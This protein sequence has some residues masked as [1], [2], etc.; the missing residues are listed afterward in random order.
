MLVGKLAFDN[1]ELGRLRWRAAEFIRYMIRAR[2][3]VDPGFLSAADYE[4]WEVDGLSSN[5]W[6]VERLLR[7]ALQLMNEINEKYLER[8]GSGG[9]RVCGE[10]PL[11]K[12]KEL[13]G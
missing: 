4:R 9:L 11:R 13:L 1:I 8:C 6:D 3:K 5:D 7:L 12:L 10:D 2:A